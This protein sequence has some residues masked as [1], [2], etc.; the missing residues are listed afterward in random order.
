MVLCK[1]FWLERIGL[2]FLVGD[3]FLVMLFGI[4]VIGVMGI[5]NIWGF[6]L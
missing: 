4:V 6:N 2:C 1:L 5:Y 3:F